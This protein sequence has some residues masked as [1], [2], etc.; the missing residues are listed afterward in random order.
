MASPDAMV[1]AA[2]GVVCC[3]RIEPRSD[4][5]VAEHEISVRSKASRHVRFYGP[6][7]VSKQIR[8]Y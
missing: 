6:S 3:M 2:L 8:F 5:R 4:R 1:D 7:G